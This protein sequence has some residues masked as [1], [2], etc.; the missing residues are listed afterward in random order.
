MSFFR[1]LRFLILDFFFFSLVTIILFS[2]DSRDLCSET[3]SR[4]VA[5]E[6]E[7]CYFTLAMVIVVQVVSGIANISYFALGVSYL[8][9]NTKKKH[10]AGLIGFLISVKI[11]G[12]LVGCML[13]W[14]CL[15]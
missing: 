8:D 13:A 7:F 12:I 5:K 10:I 9:D 4:I 2:D 15:R 14:I 11:F 6:N 3:T 1:S